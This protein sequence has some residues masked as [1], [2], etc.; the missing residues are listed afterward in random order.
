LVAGRGSGFLLSGT[1]TKC[2]QLGEVTVA[3][4]EM[5]TALSIA[6]KLAGDL[7]VFSKRPDQPDHSSG[8]V[9]WN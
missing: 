6:A 3:Q 9:A 1:V 7:Q 2:G 5:G 4:V 8:Q